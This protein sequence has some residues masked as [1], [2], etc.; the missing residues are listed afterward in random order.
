MTTYALQRKEASSMATI[1]RGCSLA[2]PSTTI[3][4]GS[5]PLSVYK[6]GDDAGAA[7]RSWCARRVRRAV[8][9]AVE[10]AWGKRPAVKVLVT[11][12]R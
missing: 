12:L 8:R 6:R 7:T 9:A 10:D 4:R 11:Q 3:R 1:R 2:A 5:T